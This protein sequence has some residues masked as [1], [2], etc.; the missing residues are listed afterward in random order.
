MNIQYNK[1]V[2]NSVNVPFGR[3]SEWYLANHPI[4]KG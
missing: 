3:T 2:E 4:F 1:D